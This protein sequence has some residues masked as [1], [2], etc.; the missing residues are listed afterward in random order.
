MVSR[1]ILGGTILYE[2]QKNSPMKRDK[3]FCACL[4]FVGSANTYF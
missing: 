3:F 1:R 4:Y 2:K